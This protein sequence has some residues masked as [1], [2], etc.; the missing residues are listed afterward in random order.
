MHKIEFE[1]KFDSLLMTTMIKSRELG[2]GLFNSGGVDTAKYEDNYELP[3]LIM[4]AVLEKMAHEWE[5]YQD[6]REF[7][8]NLR[9]LSHF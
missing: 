7:N 3:K 9:N 5:P 1:D 8:R 4:C 6:D 2:V